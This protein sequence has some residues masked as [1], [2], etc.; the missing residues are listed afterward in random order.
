MG[1][2]REGRGKIG[3]E[4][5]WV[6]GHPRGTDCSHT[7]KSHAPGQCSKA[8][9]NTLNCR[10]HNTAVSSTPLQKK[11]KIKKKAKNANQ[12]T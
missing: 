10:V 11:K 4:L 7:Y 1:V 3:E 5:P 9:N 2:F 8:R 12:N 6:A